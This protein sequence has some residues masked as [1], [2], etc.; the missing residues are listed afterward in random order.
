MLFNPAGRWNDVS[1]DS[2]RGYI[3]KKPKDG[4]VTTPPTVDN[5]RCPSGYTKWEENC[6]KYVK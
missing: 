6:Y 3:C 1:C 5:G 2:E 4:S